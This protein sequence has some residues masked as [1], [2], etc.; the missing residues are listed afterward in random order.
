MRM[1]AMIKASAWQPNRTSS[2]LLGALERNFGAATHSEIY[3]RKEALYA[4]QLLAIEIQK[5]CRASEFVEQ[6]LA[7][8]VKADL[9]L[10]EGAA[11]R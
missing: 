3:R 2:V 7:V 8:L 5:L 11:R 10:G 6:G 1:R 4:Y 9:Q